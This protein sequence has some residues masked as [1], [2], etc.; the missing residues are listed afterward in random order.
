MGWSNGMDHRGI[1]ERARPYGFDHRTWSNELDHRVLSNG[2]DHMGWSNWTGHRVCS[3]GLD[4]RVR[5]GHMLDPND[6]T[7][8]RIRS[9]HFRTGPKVKSQ[10]GSTAY[11]ANNFPPQYCPFSYNF[12]SWCYLLQILSY[13]DDYVS[14]K[15]PGSMLSAHNNLISQCHHFAIISYPNT[16]FYK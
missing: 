11:A 6:W 1:I 8:S 13:P 16:S 9:I 12:P 10:V 3:N 5:S 7:K 2:L 15:F 4:H 14:L